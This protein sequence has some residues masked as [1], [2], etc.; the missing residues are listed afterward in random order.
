MTWTNPA[1]SGSPAPFAGRDVKLPVMQ[2]PQMATK[3]PGGPVRPSD[4]YAHPATLWEA[5]MLHFLMVTYA[6]DQPSGPL[7]RKIRYQETSAAGA[8]RMLHACRVRGRSAPMSRPTHT[9]HTS[10]TAHHGA[11][12]PVQPIGNAPTDKCIAKPSQRVTAADRSVPFRSRLAVAFLPS[13][14]A[15]HYFPVRLAI[16]C[17]PATI[18]RAIP[19]SSKTK[20][21]R[22]YTWI[23]R[24]A[25]QLHGIGGSIVKLTLTV[26]ILDVGGA[27]RDDRM[28]GVRCA[29]VPLWTL[30]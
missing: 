11:N 25:P 18:P 9:A 21:Q 10:A 1:S 4:P 14:R 27:T 19:Q 13:P 29:T 24:S 26:D 15:H 30:I 7:R 23:A 17:L 3:E 8:A 22:P 2:E 5:L 6:D 28:I 16:L 20:T 12:A